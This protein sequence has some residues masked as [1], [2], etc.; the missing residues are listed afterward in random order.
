MA[1]ARD[2]VKTAG[3]L[4]RNMRN[5]NRISEATPRERKEEWIRKAQIAQEL[6]I[7]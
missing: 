1:R 5:F 2:T 4:P 3:T 7:L 6:K